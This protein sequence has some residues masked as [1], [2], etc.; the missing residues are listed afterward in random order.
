MVFDY[1]EASDRSNYKFFTHFLTNAA[2]AEMPFVITNTG[3]GGTS[4]Q[5]T[6]LINAPGMIRQQ[7]GATLDS[8]TAAR[9]PLSIVLGT[10]QYS[11][12]VRFRLPIVP[13]DASGNFVCLWGFGADRVGSTDELSKGIYFYSDFSGVYVVTKNTGGAPFYSL[14]SDPLVSGNYYESELRVDET[15]NAIAY[16]NGV[17]VAIAAAPLN[18]SLGIGF[19][20]FTFGNSAAA[21]AGV[22]GYDWLRFS[23]GN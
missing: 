11:F 22:I 23:C 4:A 5:P 7:L 14:A 9:T 19:W 16:L 12:A 2:P 13:P 10:L 6:V 18:E 8:S 17:Q 3:T 15:G 21:N 20:C 1:Q